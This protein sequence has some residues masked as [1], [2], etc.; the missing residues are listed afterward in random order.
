MQAAAAVSV[1]FLLLCALGTCPPAGCGRAGKFAA[2]CGS[3]TYHFPGIFAA[4][5]R[6]CKEASPF[7]ECAGRFFCFFR[8]VERSEAKIRCG[9]IRSFRSNACFSSE[10]KEEC[11]GWE[12]GALLLGPDPGCSQISWSKALRLVS[13][14][15]YQ[16]GSGREG[17]VG[18]S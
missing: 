3:R 17:E 2:L 16:M 5:K 7:P 6:I 14:H 13:L 15:P 18:S 1:P 10:V 4:L 8:R 9:C 11:G 12:R